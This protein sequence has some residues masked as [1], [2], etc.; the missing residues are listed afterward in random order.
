MLHKYVSTA[1]AVSVDLSWKEP[2]RAGTP[3]SRAPSRLGSRSRYRCRG[4]CYDS[5]QLIIRAAVRKYDKFFLSF[6]CISF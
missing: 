1:T 6:T 3:C 4:S 2:R 5:I